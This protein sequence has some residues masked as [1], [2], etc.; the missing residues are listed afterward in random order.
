MFQLSPAVPARIPALH[1]GT[2]LTPFPSAAGSPPLAQQHTCGRH[3]C[4]HQ[5]PHL[6]AG[7]CEPRT[8]TSHVCPCTAPHPSNDPQDKARKPELGWGALVH[9]GLEPPP[10]AP[11]QPRPAPSGLSPIKNSPLSWKLVTAKSEGGGPQGQLGGAGDCSGNEDG[12]LG[13]RTLPL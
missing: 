9:S 3:T 10:P 1:R 2:T 13:P 4:E 6:P 12:L 5:A 7:T 11:Q 8:P